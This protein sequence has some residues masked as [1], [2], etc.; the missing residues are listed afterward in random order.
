MVIN[1]FARARANWMACYGIKIHGS[2]AATTG[3]IAAT[4]GA[5]AATTG[6]IAATTGTIATTTGTIAATIGTNGG[7]FVAKPS[8]TTEF[9]EVEGDANSLL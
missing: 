7:S 4:T 1:R 3:T 8:T 9:N 6:A 5:I 2:Y